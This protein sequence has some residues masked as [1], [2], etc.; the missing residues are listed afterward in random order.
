MLSSASGAMNCFSGMTDWKKMKLAYARF[1][2]ERQLWSVTIFILKYT[3]SMMICH[4]PYHC[5]YTERILIKTGTLKSDPY[6]CENFSP[7]PVGDIS[8][9][10]VILRA[11]RSEM[12]PF[13]RFETALQLQ[14]LGWLL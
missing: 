1:M 14:K 6:Q 8:T 7:Y 5:K 4:Y 10:A 11:G 9:P 3:L 13:F 2:I 12:L